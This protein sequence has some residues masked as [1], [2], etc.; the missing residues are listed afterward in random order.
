M[1]GLII[2]L[3][4][5]LKLRLKSKKLNF[6]KADST[7]RV[8]ITKSFAFSVTKYTHNESFLGVKINQI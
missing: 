2:I 1:P 8:E 3:G 7:H 4:L 5:C 6:E